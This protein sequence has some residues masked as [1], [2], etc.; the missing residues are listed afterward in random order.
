MRLTPFYCGPNNY[1][2]VNQTRGRVNGVVQYG[3]QDLQFQTL[4]AAQEYL[5]SP[6][7]YGYGAPCC[8]DYGSGGGAH[9]D[10]LSYGTHL[11]SDRAFQSRHWRNRS[12]YWWQL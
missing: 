10:P 8:N 9:C 12:N 2:V 5:Y 1:R 7:T 6:C 11:M 3:G 4:Q